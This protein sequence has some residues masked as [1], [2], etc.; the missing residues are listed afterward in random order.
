M[1]TEHV[2]QRPGIGTLRITGDIAPGETFNIEDIAFAEFEDLDGK[3]HGPLSKTHAVMILT[4]PRRALE[5]CGLPED[6]VE[7]IRQMLGLG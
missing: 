5:I 1:L 2:Y 6:E 7:E 4:T 3:I